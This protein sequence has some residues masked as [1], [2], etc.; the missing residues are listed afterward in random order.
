M[1]M[2]K[3]DN[4]II[5]ALQELP[6]FDYYQP[7]RSEVKALESL[8]FYTASQKADCFSGP[9]PDDINAAWRLFEELSA[10]EVRKR[11]AD[12]VYSGSEKDLAIAFVVASDV[13]ATTSSPCANCTTFNELVE[14]VREKLYT[15]NRAAVPGY[16]FN[17][18]HATN[19]DLLDSAV[20]YDG[21]TDVE[22]VIGFAC[23]TILAAMS[24]S[25][26]PVT[27][28]SDALRR[29]LGQTLQLIVKREP[30]PSRKKVV[31]IV[32][33]MP[34]HAFVADCALLE[35]HE[36]PPGE[37]CV[38]YGWGNQFGMALSQA[39]ER[40]T[41]PGGSW[42]KNDVSGWERSVTE[43]SQVWSN[44]ILCMLN[45][46]G[47]FMWPPMRNRAISLANAAY[48]LRNGVV[49][50][51]VRGC[52]QVSGHKFTTVGNAVMRDSF[53]V[54]HG[55]R[56]FHNGDDTIEWSSFPLDELQQRY[57]NQGLMVR[58]FDHCTPYDF[59]FSSHQFRRT[60]DEITFEHVGP[61]KSIF[62]LLGNGQTPAQVLQLLR[63]NFSHYSV[64]GQ[65]REL[66]RKAEDKLAEIGVTY[67]QVSD[68]FV[69]S[70]WSQDG[71]TFAETAPLCQVNH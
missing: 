65:F 46:H 22:R 39:M 15:C 41:R 49:I 8:D 61:Q 20:V 70:I 7:D 31:R 68:E 13:N 52:L 34:L 27:G 36:A 35:F 45:Q 18:N 30:H 40:A 10:D 29:R 60:G 3:D 16:P 4:D 67:D 50:R 21:Y 62:R 1:P 12:D 6:E 32:I 37:S 57:I 25:D 38:M 55:G 56:A 42:A 24:E 58:D 28:A 2:E 26:T 11:L 64:T 53:T 17:K 14:V 9:P 19:G 48:I 44:Y 54:S 23:F 5:K 63:N 33:A 69:E 59:E 47:Q 66:L 71:E 51:K 43:L